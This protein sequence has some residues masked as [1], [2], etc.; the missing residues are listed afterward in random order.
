MPDKPLTFAEH[1]D[2]GQELHQSR[3]RVQ[4]LSRMVLDVYG[5]NNRCAFAF[6]KLNEAMDRLI[7]ELARQ[8]V[9]DC[10]GEDAERLYR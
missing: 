4:Q 5:P 7:D 10:P 2:L 1:R 9:A 6:E 3:R 8:A